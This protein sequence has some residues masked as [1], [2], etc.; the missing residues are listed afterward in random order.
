VGAIM[1]V[2]GAGCGSGGNDH[3]EVRGEEKITYL[4]DGN[5]HRLR[6]NNLHREKQSIWVF[7]AM[8]AGRLILQRAS[9]A[10]KADQATKHGR[11]Q[12]LGLAQW[13]CRLTNARTGRSHLLLVMTN[14]NIS[15][16]NQ[17]LH[18]NY[19]NFNLSHM[20]LIQRSA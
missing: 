1:P 8:Q 16:G 2:H 18:E 11:L 17:P 9:L 5:S 13:S 4:G 6:R 15:G 20:M 12:Q 14:G 10:P 19:G 7:F 3:V